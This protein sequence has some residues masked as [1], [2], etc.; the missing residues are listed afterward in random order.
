[1]D[2]P[3]LIAWPHHLDVPGML[4]RRLLSKHALVG[5]EGMTRP[6]QVLWLV[7]E[8]CEEIANGGLAQYFGNS[9]AE[10]AELV[11]EALL[12][13]GFAPLARAFRV[14][15]ASTRHPAAL[16]AFEQQVDAVSEPLLSKLYAWVA[17][18]PSE[19]HFANAGLCAFRPVEIPPEFSLD[20]VFADGVP[21]DAIIPALY[22]RW[23]ARST[24]LSAPERQL[25]LAI[26]AFAEISDEGP[27]SYFFSAEGSDAPQAKEALEAI[28][29]T[30]AAR[31]LG[32]AL[33]LFQWSADVATR[34][35]ALAALDVDARATLG[36]LQWDM[37]ALREPTLEQ[38]VAF[39]R[40]HRSSLK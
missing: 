24:P 20:E 1:M 40:Q 33:S 38:L 32:K 7:F 2:V 31:V 8:L 19:F 21:A 15:V 18:R 34:R 11:P 4:F 22:I 14:V 17:A 30:E 35:A 25:Q 39:A 13:L 9:S 16:Q 23:A 3:D 27:V 12:E 29:A 5:L 26:H 28:G 6:E 36:K 37:D 10:R